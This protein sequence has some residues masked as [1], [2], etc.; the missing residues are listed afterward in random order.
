MNFIK[1]MLAAVLTITLP[2]WIVPVVLLGIFATFFKRV[3]ALI[4][5]LLGVKK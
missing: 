4:S 2:V 3:Y 1:K 5:E